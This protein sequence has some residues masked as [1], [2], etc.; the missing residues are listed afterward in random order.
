MKK[1]MKDA[2]TA[3][4]EKVQAV[5]NFLKDWYE[6]ADLFETAANAGSVLL[7]IPQ[8]TIAADDMK[9]LRNLIDQHVMMA[10]VLKKFENKDAE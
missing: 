1:E 10:N 5:E 8:G 9:W 3:S 2:M 7:A 4:I 6:V